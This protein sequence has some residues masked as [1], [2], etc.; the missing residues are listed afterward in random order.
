MGNKIWKSARGGSSLWATAA[1]ILVPG[2]LAALLAGCGG[3]GAGGINK[4]LEMQCGDGYNRETGVV[5]ELNLSGQA[6][7]KVKVFL[8]TA[9]K[10]T[11]AVKEIESDALGACRAI[12]KDLGAT[13]AELMV[14]QADKDKDPG[15]EVKTVCQKAAAKIKQTIED[16]VPTEASLTVQ[17]T[18]AKCEVSAAAQIECTKTCEMKEVTETDIQCKPGK[19]SGTCGAMCMGECSGKCEGGCTGSCTAEC[20]GKCEGSVTAECTGKCEGQCDGTC[21][22]MGANGQ[23]AGKC[24]GTCVGKCDVAVKGRC[25]GKCM[26]SCSGSCTG[27]CMAMCT[28]S[29]SGG[30][31]VMYT[32][33]KCEEIEVKKQVT[34]CTQTCD[35]SARAEAKCEAPMVVVEFRT[36][37]QPD[38]ARKMKLEALVTT[39]K[40]NLPKFLKAMAKAGN[41]TR[42]TF[43]AYASALGKIKGEIAGSLKATAC[44]GTALGQNGQDAQKAGG[45]GAGGADLL[46]SL[47]AKGKA[48]VAKIACDGYAPDTGGKGP[49]FTGAGGLKLNAVMD[50]SL[51]LV[52][53]A[54]GIEADTLGACKAMGDKLGIMTPSD[55]KGACAAVKAEIDRIIGTLM[56]TVKVR[57]VATPP[58]CTINAMA[59]FTCTQ[60]CEMKTITQTDLK[61]RPGKLSGSCGAT[62]MGQCKGSCMASVSAACSGS[63]M[64]TCTGKVSAK[65]TGMCTGTCTVGAM[66]TQ[67]T[68]AACA[69][70]CNGQCMG[71]IEG[72][73]DARCDGM[74]MGN[75]E[76]TCMG[77]CSGSCT[78]GCSITY[79]APYCE[80]VEVMKDVTECQQSCDAKAKCD[81]MC[82][83]GNVTIAVDTNLD[84]EKAKVVKLVDA[85]K[86]GL[87]VLFKVTKRIKGTVEGSVN[88]YVDMVKGLPDT[89][90]NSGLMGAGCVAAV[91]TYSASATAKITASAEA[92]LSVTTAAIA[93]AN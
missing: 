86:T 38:P 35:A 28:G 64:G 82:F 31:S 68:N 76:G 66:D 4:A 89:I 47:K 83:P 11:A 48:V 65:C 14:A 51:S 37:L 5:G 21:D 52:K 10:I 79:M 13:D 23:C 17:Y 1:L 57:V 71:T 40:T 43:D 12:A 49:T 61:C 81:A 69:G 44:V 91:V 22:V 32:A 58:Y 30:C 53:A 15:L 6:S 80:E 45:A 87:P 42:A 26:G 75:V 34:E 3:D 36:N 88:A 29:C 60:T 33:P 25:D 27:S 93:R 41:T 67:V 74:C 90:K 54:S 56:P 7:A 63:C 70:T 84:A 77:M 18:P 92:A 39:L 46:T 85:L 8:G 73:C 78:G 62:C 2:S 20:T 19:L 9:G 50:A 72:S 16:N 24:T 55:V 59:S